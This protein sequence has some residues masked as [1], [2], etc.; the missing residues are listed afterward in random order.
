MEVVVD[1]P[2]HEAHLHV[3]VG[4]RVEGKKYIEEERYASTTSL[5]SAGR[6]TPLFPFNPKKRGPDQCAPVISRAIAVN[7]R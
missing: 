4:A 1:Q 6:S 2:R 5:A 3:S 7:D